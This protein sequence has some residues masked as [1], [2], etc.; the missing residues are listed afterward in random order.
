MLFS[1]ISVRSALHLVDSDRREFDMNPRRRKRRKQKQ[2]KCVISENAYYLALLK[3]N[4]RVRVLRFYKRVLQFQCVRQDVCVMCYKCCVTELI[5]Y[6]PC[7]NSFTVTMTFNVFTFEEC[8]QS[9]CQQNIFVTALNMGHYSKGSEKPPFKDDRLR[10]YS[11]RFCPYAQ[12][13]AA[14]SLFHSFLTPRCSLAAVGMGYKISNTN[15]SRE[16]KQNESKERK[17]L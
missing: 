13:S 10:L 11:M 14:L 12:V 6:A 8:K 7:I 5:T 4:I 2:P 15:A 9:S 16:E 17:K 3:L 1:S